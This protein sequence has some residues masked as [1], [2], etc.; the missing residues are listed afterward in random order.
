LYAPQ[1][2]APRWSRT[3]LQALPAYTAKAAERYA[4]DG[5]PLTDVV[6]ET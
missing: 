6:T 3:V 4:R 5:A 2:S 1:G